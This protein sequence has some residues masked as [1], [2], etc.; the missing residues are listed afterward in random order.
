MI[1]YPHT[2]K[3][4]FVDNLIAQYEGPYIHT[5]E[6]SDGRSNAHFITAFTTGRIPRLEAM[7]LSPHDPGIYHRDDEGCFWVN[8]YFKRGLNKGWTH[9]HHWRLDES[10]T[11]EDVERVFEV[12]DDGIRAE[13]KDEIRSIFE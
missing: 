10:P 4:R 13:L 2:D 12:L 8:R 3:T 5:V 11:L 6:I 7:E 1:E 9:H